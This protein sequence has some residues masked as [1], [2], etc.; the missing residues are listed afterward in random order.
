MKLILVIIH[1]INMYLDGCGILKIYFQ[2]F[3]GLKIKSRIDKKI[4]FLVKNK[5]ENI[6][7]WCCWLHRL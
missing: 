6:N 3:G 2:V 5:Y 1:Q 4:K 7:N